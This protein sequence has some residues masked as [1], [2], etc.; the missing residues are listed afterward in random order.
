MLERWFGRQKECTRKQDPSFPT[1]KAL[2]NLVSPPLFHVQNESILLEH[3]TKIELVLESFK[4]S[5]L[6]TAI[7]LT[8]NRAHPG[9][10]DSSTLKY[11]HGSL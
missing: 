3:S 7:Q 10:P 5:L 6:Y 11:G 9:S 2:L 4:Y 1:R 8:T